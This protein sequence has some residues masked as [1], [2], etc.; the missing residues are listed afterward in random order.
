MAGKVIMVKTDDTFPRL[1]PATALEF[2]GTTQTVTLHRPM[3]CGPGDPSDSVPLERCFEFDADL[4]NHVNALSD[5][6]INSR[7][8]AQQLC[9]SG[10]LQAQFLVDGETDTLVTH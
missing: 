4:M 5:A 1:L 3:P 7:D 9:D 8:A 10:L 2:D 6:A